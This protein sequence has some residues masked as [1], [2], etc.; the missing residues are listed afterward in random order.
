MKE[1]ND[2]DLKDK[3]EK[4]EKEKEK[5]EEEQED[6]EGKN[7]AKTEENDDDENEKGAKDEEAEKG[8]EARGIK[9]SRR[10]G[11]AGVRR[12]LSPGAVVL[13]ER[14]RRPSWR[15]PISSGAREKEVKYNETP[16]RPQARRPSC[17]D[18]D[19]R[20]CLDQDA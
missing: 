18:I 8:K 3:K 16:K 6:K 14:S 1:R 10:G 17:G 7:G 19:P 13:T 9:G 11:R 20:K 2:D 4:E 5:K 12:L 15:R